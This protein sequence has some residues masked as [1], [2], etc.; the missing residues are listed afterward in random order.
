[1]QGSAFILNN[2]KL[3]PLICN[4]HINKTY[5]RKYNYKGPTNGINVNAGFN[6]VDKYTCTFC[7]YMYIFDC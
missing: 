7:M 5:C 4:H 6:P 1:M 3:Y 2:V